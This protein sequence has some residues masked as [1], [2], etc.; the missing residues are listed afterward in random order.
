[1]PGAFKPSATK[2]TKV[3]DHFPVREFQRYPRPDLGFPKGAPYPVDWVPTRLQD[4]K[5]ALEVIRA[6]LGGKPVTIGSGY[7][8]PSYNKAIGGAKASQHMAGRAAD[9]TVAGVSPAKVH[10]T[11]LRLCEE[12]KLPMVHGLGEYPTFTHVDVRPGKKLVR[13]KGSRKES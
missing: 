13:W 6:E 2:V 9:I 10:A 11:V 5:E 1:M 4:L 7:R 12:G 3:V 8:D